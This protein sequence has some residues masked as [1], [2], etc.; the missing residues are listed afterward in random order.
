MHFSFRRTSVV[1]VGAVW[2]LLLLL[3]AR[4]EEQLMELGEFGLDSELRFKRFPQVSPHQ[5]QWKKNHSRPI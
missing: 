4:G 3:A 5:T 2:C 1:L